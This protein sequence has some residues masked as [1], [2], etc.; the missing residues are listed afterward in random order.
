[1]TIVRYWLTRR[2]VKTSPYCRCAACRNLTAF[3]AKSL[4]EPSNRLPLTISGSPALLQQDRTY[5]TLRKAEMPLRTHA[6]DRNNAVRMQARS[7]VACIRRNLTAEALTYGTRCRRTSQFYP[8][9]HAFSHERNQPYSHLP[10]QSKLVLANR[11]RRN[12]RLSLPGATT[13][14]KHRAHAGTLRCA[15]AV[16]SCSNRHASLSNWV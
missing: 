2:I 14:R 15:Y 5:R 7:L 6:A 11:T 9:I 13:A 1:M 12:G 16:V 10:S 8:Q 3:C 4:A